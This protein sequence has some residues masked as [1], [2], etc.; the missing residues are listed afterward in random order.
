[1]T[2]FLTLALISVLDPLGALG[3][4]LA[5]LLCRR[6]WVTVTVALTY[7]VVLLFVIRTPAGYIWPRLFGAL[8][9][10]SGM[11]LIFRL[12]RKRRSTLHP[13]RLKQ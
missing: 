13:V 6:Y 4:L 9:F 12:I 10:T 8:V 5:A 1:M 2:L 7:Q 3:S 11:Y